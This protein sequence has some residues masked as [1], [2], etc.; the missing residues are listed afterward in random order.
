VDGSKHSRT[1]VWLM[2]GSSRLPQV[3]L[4]RPSDDLA[5]TIIG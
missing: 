4:T 2:A 3:Y 1:T 5:G